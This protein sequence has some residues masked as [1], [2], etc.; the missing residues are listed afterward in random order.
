MRGETKVYL[1]TGDRAWGTGT[2]S[3]DPRDDLRC[4]CDVLRDVP[5]GSVLIHG[6][7]AGADRMAGVQW[8][9]IVQGPVVQVPYFGYLRRAGGPARNR[10]M[11]DLLDLYRGRGHPCYVLAFHRDLVNSRGTADMVQIAGD[12]GYYVTL[13]P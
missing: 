4:L 2:A 9:K 3:V 12:A 13:H 1:V 5:R 6:N 8:G 7:A 10:F 11:L